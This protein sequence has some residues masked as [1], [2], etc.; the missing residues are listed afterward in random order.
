VLHVT[1][2]KRRLMR[3][4]PHAVVCCSV[5]YLGAFIKS[6]WIAEMAKVRDRS[7]I[8]SRAWFNITTANSPRL[9]CITSYQRRRYNSRV[10]RQRKFPRRVSALELRIIYLQI[11]YSQNRK[12]L[13]ILRFRAIN[14]RLRAIS[15]SP[16]PYPFL[17]PRSE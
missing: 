1:K 15:I 11:I 8:Y 13:A 5:L 16:L 3:Q 12:G 10:S 2:D 4:S 17:C 9:V 14:S 6:C 7:R